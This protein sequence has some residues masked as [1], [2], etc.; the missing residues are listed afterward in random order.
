MAWW[1]MPRTNLR[2]DTIA[3]PGLC[4]QIRRSSL[5]LWMK[6]VKQKMENNFTSDILT[7]SD[8]LLAIPSLNSFTIGLSAEGSGKKTISMDVTTYSLSIDWRGC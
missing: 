8:K 4:T 7:S 3:R 5:A 2:P 1:E 6:Q